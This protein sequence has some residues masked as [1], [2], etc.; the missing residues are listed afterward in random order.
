M[1]ERSVCGRR[2]EM[3]VKRSAV[4]WART[5]VTMRAN[6]LAPGSRIFQ[7][8]NRS[9]ARA[10]ISGADRPSKAP[11]RNQARRLASAAASKHGAKRV[12]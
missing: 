3:V 9:S 1:S 8:R 4:V 11:S 2:A 10:S 6:V 5:V 7:P 12:S